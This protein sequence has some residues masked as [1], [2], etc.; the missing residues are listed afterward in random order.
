MMQR[1]VA[2]SI[3]LLHILSEQLQCL[4]TIFANQN[5]KID[6]NSVSVQGNS[7]FHDAQFSGNA[8]FTNMRT[9]GNL[10]LLRTIFGKKMA[11]LEGIRV[12]GKLI[13]HEAQFG[14]TTVFSNGQIS[15]SFEANNI[16]F[17]DQDRGVFFNNVQTTAITISKGKFLGPVDFSL[18][19]A[20]MFIIYDSTF[21]NNTKPVDFRGIKVQVNFVLD[22]TR[23]SGPVNFDFANITGN[24][25][26][27]ETRYLSN[28]KVSLRKITIG[29]RMLF[30]DAILSSPVDL[31]SAS[32]QDLIIEDIPG[33]G[34]DTRG[35]DTLDFSRSVVTGELRL[36]N[37]VFKRIIANS[38]KVQGPA[39]FK[40][41]TV[42]DDLTLEA[43]R[44]T[45]LTF[46]DFLYSPT[47]RIR[48]RGMRY[49]A[50]DGNSSNEPE[51]VE[52]FLRFLDRS[53]YDSGAYQQFESFLKSQGQSDAVDKVYASSTWR[54]KR[55]FRG[56]M[57]NEFEEGFIYHGRKP[58]RAFGWGLIFIF[59]GVLFFYKKDWMEL[60][61][62]KKKCHYNPFWYAIGIF[63]PFIKL[64]VANH[65]QPRQDRKIARHVVYALQLL[66]WFL[67]TIGVLSFSG[68]IK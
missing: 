9:G 60:I 15:G 28:E 49:E 4:R 3:S 31:E 56:R 50:V 20:D 36:E 21:E 8:F 30:K 33:K 35:V 24:F 55:S 42:S 10:E 51:F 40:K 38:A 61:D 16:R 54:D 37:V 43:T 25:S 34:G 67:L 48:L 66:G 23:F 27:I 47:C 64:Q 26:A 45:S 12:G 59:I 52:W 46:S 7:F 39:V 68:I 62:D 13:A 63:V 17:L 29:G 1:F 44:F 57:W 18:T 11:N 6:F 2:R 5:A 58:Y 22:K 14:G 19:K 53:E 32:I 65:W 41:V